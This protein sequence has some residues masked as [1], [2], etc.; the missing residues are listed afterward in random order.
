MWTRE[1]EAFGR[2]RD[3]YAVDGEWTRKEIHQSH[4]AI[5]S[6]GLLVYFLAA[7]N[8]TE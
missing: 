1:N 4:T 2:E 3:M 8:F 5:V 6:V 7:Y